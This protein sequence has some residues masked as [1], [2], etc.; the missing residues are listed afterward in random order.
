MLEYIIDVTKVE[1]LQT[2]RDTD[3]LENIFERAKS[4][5]VQGGI[6]NLTRKST[7]GSVNKFDAI[8]TEAD[9][10]TYKASV[11]KYL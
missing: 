4:T 3:A 8:S 6:V 2:I 1:E 11:F 7:D 9:L 5:V 10:D